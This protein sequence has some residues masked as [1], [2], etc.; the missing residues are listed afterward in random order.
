MLLAV[1]SSGCLAAVLLAGV[2]GPMTFSAD[3][4]LDR[5]RLG[6]GELDAGTELPQEESAVE[7]PL[8]AQPRGGIPVEVVLSLA[9]AIVAGAL[10]VRSVLRARHDE[11]PDEPDEP[12]DE[13]GT[14]N[15][16]GALTAVAE[17]ARLGLARLDGAEDGN[18]TEVVLACWVELEAAG[19][20]LGSGRARTDT[21]TDF[22]RRLAA[23]V[24]GLDPDVLGDLRRTYSR[25]R[26]G[27]AGAVGAVDAEDV[28]RAR[29]ALEHLLAA[30][31]PGAP[32]QV[33]R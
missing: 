20:R 16:P 1:A 24:P 9:A 6:Q 19:A 5:L 7:V 28:R 14:G 23:A 32:Q 8:P 3:S 33:P 4:P 25:V 22:A 27:G 29:A 2:L 10:L 26:H 11:V 31:E 21:P 30:I 17:A 13:L 18:A 12:D 15:D